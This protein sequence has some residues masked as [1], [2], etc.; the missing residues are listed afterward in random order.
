VPSALEPERELEPG[1]PGQG[2][3]DFDD[4]GVVGALGAVFEGELGAGV[5]VVGAPVAIVL[6]VPLLDVLE[7][8]AAVAM[9]VTAPA[10]RAPATIVAPRSFE[11]FI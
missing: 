7:L 10:P 6:V 3:P 8:P 4:G 2:W 5:V 1:W 9:P 11:M